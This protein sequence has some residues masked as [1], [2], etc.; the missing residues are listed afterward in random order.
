MNAGTR[1]AAHI[2]A[3]V[4]FLIVSSPNVGPQYSSLIGSFV[5]A[6]GKLPAFSTSTKS[7]TSCCCKFALDHRRVENRLGLIV[8]AEYSRPSRMTA[9]L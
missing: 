2:I 7:F 8:G 9:N 6:A 5:R 4:L 3:F 1:I